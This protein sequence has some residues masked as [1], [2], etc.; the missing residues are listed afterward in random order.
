MTPEER[1]QCRGFNSSS[2]L[3]RASASAPVRQSPLTCPAG[4]AP[5]HSLSRRRTSW[6]F[7]LM[8]RTTGDLVNGSTCDWRAAGAVTPVKDQGQCGS[9]WAFSATGTIIRCH[10]WQYISRN[11][12]TRHLVASH[13]CKDWFLSTSRRRYGERVVPREGTAP[14]PLRAEPRG[15]QLARAEPGLQRRTARARVRYEICGSFE[16]IYRDILDCPCDDSL[17]HWQ[18]TSRSTASRARRIIRYVF[19]YFVFRCIWILRTIFYDYPA[20]AFTVHRTRWQV[21]VQRLQNRGH[22]FHPPRPLFPG[23]SSS[24]FKGGNHPEAVQGEDA[25]ANAITTVGPIS[26][27]ID[28]S[29]EYA[30]LPLLLPLRRPPIRLSCTASQFVPVLLVRRVL[31]ARMPHSD[32]RPRGTRRRHR[33]RQRHRLLHRQ[34]QVCSSM[35]DFEASWMLVLLT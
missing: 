10:Q 4:I 8:T 2:L 14:E 34:E 28:A 9:C 29:H 19:F 12:H 33:Q 23:S 26:V 18:I 15:L 17:R 5:L 13:D 30:S 11:K 3:T 16:N 22:T 25:L 6:Q 7:I 24:F 1:R 27:A 20:D 21:P 31:R 35:S 32:T